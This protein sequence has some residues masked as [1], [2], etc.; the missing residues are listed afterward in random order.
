[1]INRRPPYIQMYCMQTFRNLLFVFCTLFRGSTGK[2]STG[3]KMLAGKEMTIFYIHAYSTAVR[4]NFLVL[5]RKIAGCLQFLNLSVLGPAKVRIHVQLYRW[6]IKLLL[7]VVTCPFL[8]F[9]NSTSTYTNANRYKEA[10]IP[11]LSIKLYPFLYL[12]PYDFEFFFKTSL[13]F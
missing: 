6:K 2:Y 7:K 13:C 8:V 4:R 1:M 9:V 12:L 5:L 3:C 11:T 10:Y